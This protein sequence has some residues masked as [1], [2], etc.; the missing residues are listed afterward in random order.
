LSLYRHL[1]L[2]PLLAVG[3]WFFT[4]HCSDPL[5]D[6]CTRTLTCP[7]ESEGTYTLGPDCIWRYPSGM[8]WADGPAKGSD[9]VW[10]WN[11][12]TG[13]PV[14]RDFVCGDDG[15]SAGG[16]AGS[17]GGGGSDG[18]GTAGTGGDGAVDSG[19]PEPEPPP[20]TPDC[21]TNLECTPP[22]Q[23]DE[24]TG[25][26]VGCVNDTPCAG[27]IA[28]RCSEGSCVACVEHTDC[29]TPGFS[30]CDQS[31]H[32]CQPCTDSAQCEGGS[33]CNTTLNGGTCVQC[34]LDDQCEAL[35]ETPQCK[36]ETGECVTCTGDEQ[37]VA[38]RDNSRCN[39]TTNTCAP[40]N[41]DNQCPDAFPTCDVDGETAR[42]VACTGNDAPSI[43]CQNPAAANCN[44]S[45]D[46]VACNDSDQCTHLPG[47]LDVCNMANGRCVECVNDDDCD[48]VGDSRC[49][50]DTNTCVECTRNGATSIG[51][52]G[53]QP[54]GTV[55]DTSFN[56]NR[57]VQCTGEIF[58]ACAGGANVCDSRNRTCTQFP[59][60]SAADCS[61]CVS[62]AQCDDGARC[63]EQFFP[64][65]PPGASLGFF[66]M[67]PADPTNV[68]APCG[69]AGR[70]Y[71]RRFSAP[72]I[73]N[74][75]ADVC[76]LNATSCVAF[77]DFRTARACTSGTDAATCGALNTDDGVCD[78]TGLG[79]Q[80]SVP[81]LTASDCTGTL[82]C[83]SG[84][85]D[86]P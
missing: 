69:D 70:P 61:P 58:T 66:C 2:A 18:G 28:P 81:C 7:T 67:L 14:G 27:T 57:C 9:G 30:R 74:V 64:N 5:A 20:P 24:D 62:D 23:C 72:S 55:C 43:T 42:C 54:G 41:N 78:A 32:A 76:G 82:A 50:L 60:E 22:T 49:D 33:L 37:C 26:C 1:R 38:D 48:A 84:F 15:I 71:A 80:C 3:S 47:S 44:A 77:N 86:L 4:T 34:L 13:E 68:A 12:G 31:T 25:E 56:P 51:C 8:R 45:G 85:C 17:G 53:A 73:D 36:E 59:A 10:R 75:A 46:C 6:D 19:V 40:C 83:P 35:T 21:N 79:F 11:N 39:L 52:G 29:T 65:D 63:V 16:S